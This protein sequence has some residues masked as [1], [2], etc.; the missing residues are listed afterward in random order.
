MMCLVR[1]LYLN[2][3]LEHKQK[4][5]SFDIWHDFVMSIVLVNDISEVLA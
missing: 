2:N 3:T 5:V 4:W 1:H